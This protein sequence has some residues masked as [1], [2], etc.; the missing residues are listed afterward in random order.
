MKLDA[1]RGLPPAHTPRVSD[2]LQALRRLGDSDKVEKITEAG[3]S[4][5]SVRALSA[6]HA[7]KNATTVWRSLAKVVHVVS[8]GRSAK[9]LW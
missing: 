6:T 2:R 4:E 8:R 9:K 5:K 3:L 1:G 7:A